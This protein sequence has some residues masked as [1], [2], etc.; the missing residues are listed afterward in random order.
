MTDPARTEPAANGAGTIAVTGVTG[1]LGGQ[2]VRLLSDDFRVDLRLLARDP[3]R[4]PDIDTDIRACEYGDLDASVAAL[5]GVESLLMVSASESADRRTEHRT[6]VRAAVEAGVRHIVYT[7]FAGAAADA[8]FTLG[9]DHHD[10]EQAIRDSGLDFTFLRDSFYLDVL[11]LFADA[12]GVIRG[13][14]GDGRVAAVARADVADVAAAVLRDPD[15]H[16]GATYTLTGPEALSLAD[17]A[18]RAGA[19]LGRPLRFV[20]ES[21]EEAYAWRREQ[22]GAAD[23]QLDAWVSTYTAIRDDTLAEVS[24]DVERLTGHPPRTLEDAL[25]DG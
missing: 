13:P 8:A 22:Y 7:S 15:A 17:V 21:V 16:R 5:H 25:T 3:D 24:P 10:T 12:E 18:E 14:A 1:A 19:V 6:F 11:P 4:A 20:D 23:W 9:R 2:V